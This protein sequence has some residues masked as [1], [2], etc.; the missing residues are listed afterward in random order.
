MRL[1]DA[2]NRLIAGSACAGL[3]A[4]L[5]ALADFLVRSAGAPPR[6]EAVADLV[7]ILLAIAVQLTVTA[8]LY[9]HSR[10]HPAPAAAR[11]YVVS[12]LGVGVMALILYLGGAPI[13]VVPAALLWMILASAPF[14]LV[15]LSVTTLLALAGVTIG[16]LAGATISMDTLTGIAVALCIPL[17]LESVR[18]ISARIQAAH[19]KV[20]DI[21]A[22]LPAEADKASSAAPATVLVY[23]RNAVSRH[24]LGRVLAGRGTSVHLSA[25]IEDLERALGQHSFKTAVMDFES[26]DHDAAEQVEKA[27][28]AS[29]DLDL[30]MIA[31]LPKGMSNTRFG[32]G[33]LLLDKP[34][35]LRTFTDTVLPSPDEQVEEAPLPGTAQ[36]NPE[37]V[38]L[39]LAALR[40]LR[41]LGG[42]EFVRE[43][44]DQ[45]VADAAKV[46]H[47]LAATVAGADVREFRDQVHALRSC[48]ANVG[49]RGIYELCLLW[50]AMEPDDLVAN[51]AAHIKRLNEAFVEVRLSLELYLEE[52]RQEEMRAA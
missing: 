36:F 14:G 5:M 18:P 8:Y 3:F 35:N 12:V 32:S 1:R 4:G 11:R 23:S 13:I 33:D 49:A 16:T 41:T 39:D 27:R 42:D 40:D 28:L 34:V 52:A 50:R 25:D 26:S 51:G 22:V 45:F 43:I 7:A 44:I 2:E 9:L 17:L 30:R 38:A 20:Q 46:L 47:A 10:K 21:S 6:S 19:T 37:D 31:L 29:R 24:V 15:E 48:A